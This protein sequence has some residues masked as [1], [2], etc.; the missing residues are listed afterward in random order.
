MKIITHFPLPPIPLQTLTL[1]YVASFKV[2]QCTGQI[3]N[4]TFTGN[5]V[6]VL[7]TQLRLQT[8]ITA[9]ISTLSTIYSVFLGVNRP[10]REFDHP[11]P[12]SAKVKN[13]RR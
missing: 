11:T 1:S 6:A 8:L 4:T 7:P 3:N 2:M 12:S 10:N 5:K 13:V 9:I